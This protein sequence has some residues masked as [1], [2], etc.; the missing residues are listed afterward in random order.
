MTGP[1]LT[2]RSNDP[3]RGK[4]SS[5]G[6]KG[7][8]PLGSETPAGPIWTSYAPAVSGP[9]VAPAFYSLSRAG[10]THGP[11]QGGGEGQQPAS[12][13]RG[14][15]LQQATISQHERGCRVQMWKEDRDKRGPL[16]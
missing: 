14:K 13:D 4:E 1:R 3:L 5:Q 10:R 8:S 9:T 7:E 16:E 12:P 11:S 2:A 6:G 15:R